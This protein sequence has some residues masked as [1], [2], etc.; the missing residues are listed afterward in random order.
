MVGIFGS[1][2]Y[3]LPDGNG[4]TYHEN[5]GK[6]KPGKFSPYLIRTDTTPPTTTA[7]PPG[8]TYTSTQSVTLSANEPA[9]IYY[10]TNGSKPTTSSPTYSSPISI[11]TTTTLKFFAKDTAGNSESVKTASYT[12]SVIQS[13]YADNFGIKEI[14]HTKVGGM[15]WYVSMDN[16]VNDPYFKNLQ[17]L[18]LIKQPDGSWQVQNPIDGQ[19]RM[20]D[21]SVQNEKWLN[22]EITEYA[23]IVDGT[24]PLL[25]I[26]G[27]GGHHTSTDKC[28]GS[29]YKARLYGDGRAAWVK[30]VNH[31]A[32][33]GIRG[34]AQATTDTLQGRWVGFKAIIYNFIENGRT[35][36]HLESYIDNNV[37]D[38][39]GNLVVSNNWKLASVYEDKG[40][41][42]AASDPDFVA[43][44][45]PMS[46]DNPGPFRQAD[47]ILSLSGGTGT[48]NLAGFRTDQITW[49]F[50]YLT[51][52]EIQP[53]TS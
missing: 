49:D 45:S 39:N 12:I 16:P 9:T 5:N 25:Q 4:N 27:R 21:W 24:N 36:V 22:V 47:E 35:Y 34:L 28:L 23:K 29:A 43:S 42:S 41:W 44:C 13:P 48:Q 20:E 38:S 10:T 17:N 19:V 46:V 15:E 18:Q 1:S 26:Y 32:Y 52:R 33:T 7:T 3:A 51:V 31:Q 11:S 40:G 50:K 14:Y 8:G 30:E 37:S 6:Y 2:V 53:P